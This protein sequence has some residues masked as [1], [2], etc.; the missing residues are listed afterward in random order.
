MSV[1]TDPL[2]RR[3]SAIVGDSSAKQLSRAFG[4]STV[5]DLL[6]HYP[7]RY[8][9]RGEVTDF[10]G[11]RDGED[12]TVVATVVLQR[13][14]PR[15]HRPRATAHDRRDDRDLLAVA[16]PREVGHLAAVRVPARVV[17]EQIADGRHAECAGEL[18]R[19]GVADDRRQ[20]AGERIGGH[21]IEASLDP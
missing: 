2:A 21:G 9:H 1:T 13:A 12:V 15:R 14:A 4:M 20:A 7:R 10:A 6:G 16:E 5:G 17:A 3:L 11:L 8:A 18:L 19:R